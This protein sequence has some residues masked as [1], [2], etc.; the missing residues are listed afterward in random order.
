M[1][2]SHLAG[3]GGDDA[4]LVDALDGDDHE[5]LGRHSRGCGRLFAREANAIA[6]QVLERRRGQRPAF[7]DVQGAVLDEIRDVLRGDQAHA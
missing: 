6:T 7:L 4:G 3:D 2:A 5:V 1:L